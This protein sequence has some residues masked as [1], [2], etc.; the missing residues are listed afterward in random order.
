VPGHLH[1]VRENDILSL[2]DLPHDG[3]TTVEMVVK[4]TATGKV[5]NKANVKATQAH[6]D[7][8]NNKRTVATSVV[9]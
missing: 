7:M 1:Q 4:P 6:P 3:I 5:S 9:P 8:A 2:G